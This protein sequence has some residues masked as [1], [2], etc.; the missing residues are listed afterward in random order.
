MT[1]VVRDKDGIGAAL[2]ILGLATRARSGGESL[3]EVYDA[4]EAAHGVHLTD[5]AHGAQPHPGRCDRAAARGG[6]DVPGR[7]GR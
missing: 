6:A 1:D 2:A 3:L 7:R 5:A 4:L